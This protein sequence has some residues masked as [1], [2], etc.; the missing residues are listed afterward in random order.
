M[1]DPLPDLALRSALA[2]LFAASAFAKLRDVDGFA[3][4]VAGYRILPARLA[5][6]AAL[7]FLA[8]ELTLVAA[9][10]SPP[11]RAAAGLG[12]AALLGLYAFAIAVNLVRGRRHIDCGCSGPGGRQAISGPLAARNA[13]LA[14]A[15]LALALP[16]AA[17]PWVWL[18]SLTLIA[19]VSVSACLYAAT[20]A[21]LACRLEPR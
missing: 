20:N 2:L 12:A 3:A 9:L 5:R 14:S 21:L 1:I 19:V 11:L 17:R 7:V 8:L 16:V 13:L 6:A 4:A 15:A 18:D 10:L